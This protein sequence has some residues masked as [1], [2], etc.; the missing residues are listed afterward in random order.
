MAYLAAFSSNI[1]HAYLPTDG[2]ITVPPTSVP[3]LEIILTDNATNTQCRIVHS[4]FGRLLLHNF[5]TLRGKSLHQHLITFHSIAGNTL[6]KI[7]D[8]D[9]SKAPPQ[10]L[11]WRAQ[12]LVI[13]R[14]GKYFSPLLAHFAY[15]LFCDN[16][17]KFSSDLKDHKDLCEDVL[18]QAR[19]LLADKHWPIDQGYVDLQLSRVCSQWCRN[20]SSTHHGTLSQEQ[21][22]A[23]KALQIYLEDKAID[24]GD[25]AHE[26]LDTFDSGCTLA[27]S[28]AFRSQK[29]GVLLATS[30][31][32]RAMSL[33]ETL[34]ETAK[35]SDSLSTSAPKL[36]RGALKYLP[37][38]CKAGAWV[39]AQVRWQT[40]EKE[41][42]KTKAIPSSGTDTHTPE[43]WTSSQ[44]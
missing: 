8:V 16:S 29:H 24:Y 35:K 38:N 17:V 2:A 18:G 34:W 20:V 30:V 28:L 43:Q 27:S 25:R 33:Y 4:L 15:H 11:C 26:K 13:N 19:E 41:H 37:D 31:A 40:R 1:Q 3:T 5:A 7:A 42:V 23:N 44:A 39:S 22:A 32:Q 21:Y 14:S 12:T 9:L 6:V 10:P 36:I